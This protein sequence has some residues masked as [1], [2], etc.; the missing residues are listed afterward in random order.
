MERANALRGA[1]AGE[2]WSGRRG[3]NPRP[4]AWKAVTLP[5]SYSRLRVYPSP[6]TLPGRKPTFAS[7][8]RP[9]RHGGGPAAAVRV[10]PPRTV[11]SPHRPPVWLRG[12]SLARAQAG[13]EGRIRTSEAARATDLQSVAFDRSA[14]SPM[15]VARFRSYP[16]FD[17]RYIP[18][19]S[20]PRRS[21]S[22]GVCS[23]LAPSAG[24]PRRRFL[25]SV[26]RRACA[27]DHPTVNDRSTHVRCSLDL[28]RAGHTVAAP[29]CH[30]LGPRE[31]CRGRSGAT[32][33]HRQH[34]QIATLDT[35]WRHSM[36][37]PDRRTPR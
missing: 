4:T 11:T 8:D 23:L 21:S 20:V 17:R 6:L 31:P 36:A 16:A 26:R 25:T 14:T 27:A 35:P 22:V 5:L 13:G 10:A 32:P 29:S 15:L 34:Q 3:S 28:A 37:R 2:S 7:T 1:S 30:Q 24:H 12:T 19:Y 33:V 18:P 9:R